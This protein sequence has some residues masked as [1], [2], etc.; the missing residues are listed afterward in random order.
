MTDLGEQ[1]ALG[2]PTAMAWEARGFATQGSTHQ[3]SKDCN[4]IP[5][6]QV[7][8]PPC[9][10]SCRNGDGEFQVRYPA[11]RRR[12]WMVRSGAGK[13]QGQPGLGTTSWMRARYS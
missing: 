4:E 5:S 11:N 2:T 1:E 7:R 9:V 6:E 12:S 13:L 8:L 3:E 10:L